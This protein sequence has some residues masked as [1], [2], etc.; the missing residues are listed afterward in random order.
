MKWI[1]EPGEPDMMLALSK[2]ESKAIAKLLEKQRNSVQRKYDHFLD[3]HEAGEATERQQ[4][5][6]FEYEDLL[7]I[8]DHFI[9]LEK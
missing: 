6:M 2:R 4:N 8:M 1:Y 3:L 9:E 7:G 5:L